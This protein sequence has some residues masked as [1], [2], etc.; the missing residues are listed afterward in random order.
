MISGLFPEQEFCL[1]EAAG[2]AGKKPY[3]DIKKKAGRSRL[4]EKK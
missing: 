4:Q 3:P 1:T 2:Q